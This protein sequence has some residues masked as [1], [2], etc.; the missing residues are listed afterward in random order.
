MDPQQ[1][2]P[3]EAANKARG[4][5]A[6]MHNPNVSEQAKKHSEQALHDIEGTGQPEQLQEA[7]E[8]GKDPGN[9]ARGL[10]AATHNPRVSQRAKEEAEERLER[11]G[12]E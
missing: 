12:G 3:E 11:M 5:K 4:Y 6:A 1:L 10:K 8:E 2:S 7:G 9:V